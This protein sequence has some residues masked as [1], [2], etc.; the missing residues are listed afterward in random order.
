MLY[1][2][3]SKS[4][5][6]LN[7]HLKSQINKHMLTNWPLWITSSKQLD[8]SVLTRKGTRLVSTNPCLWTTETSRRSS[9]HTVK[10]STR[11]MIWLSIFSRRIR[12]RTLIKLHPEKLKSL[13]TIT[14]AWW[15]IFLKRI[16]YYIHTLSKDFQNL[17]RVLLLDKARTSW[18]L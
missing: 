4:F 10:L 9:K 7:L 13:R 17:S 6:H 5:G 3:S 14:K 18:C 2:A 12:G 16:E 11:L 1:H 15:I 8:K